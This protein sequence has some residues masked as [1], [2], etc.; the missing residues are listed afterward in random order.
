MVL[1]WLVLFVG[2]VVLFTFISVYFRLVGV[3]WF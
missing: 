1:V 2:V 3:F